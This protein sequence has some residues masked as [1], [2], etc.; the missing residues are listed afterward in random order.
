MNSDPE[1]PGVPLKADDPYL[2]EL[3]MMAETDPELEAWLENTVLAP[4][5][6]A[7]P[8]AEAHP[9][10]AASPAEPAKRP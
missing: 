2:N 5:D 3:R 10:Q 9:T 7:V 4:A 1:T 8:A 6:T